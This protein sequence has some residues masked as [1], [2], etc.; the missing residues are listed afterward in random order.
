MLGFLLQAQN[1][2]NR[3]N[4]IE[5]K[6]L[7]IDSLIAEKQYDEAITLISNVEFTFKLKETDQEKLAFDYR[8]AQILYENGEEEKALEKFLKGFEKLKKT[9]ESYLYIDYINFLAKIFANSRNF[10]KAIFYNKIALENTYYNKDTLN[11]IKSLIRL[12]SFYYAKN[13]I[14][15]A[16]IFYKKVTYYPENS[17]TETRIANAYNNLGVIYQNEDNYNLAKAYANKALIIKHKQKDSLGIAYLVVNLGNLYHFEKNYREALKNYDEAMFS[18]K[19]DSSKEASFLKNVIYENLAVSYDSIGNYKNAYE[20][21]LKARD[22]NEELTNNQLAENIAEVEAKYNISKHEHQTELEKNKALRAQVLFYGLIFVTLTIIV[23]ALIFYKNYKLQQQNRIEQIQNETQTRIINA[24]IDAKEKERKNIA[25][26]LH[27]SV[28]ALLSSANLH[29]QASKAQLKSDIPPEIAKAQDIIGEASVK[30]RNLSHELISSV[31][32]KFGLAF[33]V[34]DLCQKFSNAELELISDDNGIKRYN[35]RFEIKI[36]NIIEELANNI[37]KHSKAKNATI[38]LI[39]RD[40]NQLIIQIIDD[41]IG[42][43]VK[44]GRSKNGLGLSHIE[45]R[46]KVMKGVFNINSKIGEGTSVFISVPIYNTEE[47]DKTA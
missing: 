21:L 7:K 1:I 22:L 39:E 3:Q 28:S 14:D 45:A 40:N 18:I 33:A 42:F 41:G 29:I 47:K 31:L 36:Y 23:L 25:E 13:D 4:Y 27:D 8:Y 16:K 43:D 35:Q 32:L 26:I 24:T 17:K 9:P 30:I 34:D 46:V 11:Q 12:G 19:N 44:K 20:Y 6:L 38:N 2:S 15:S 10:D 37:I 5:N